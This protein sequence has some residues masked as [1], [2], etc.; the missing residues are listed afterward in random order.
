[1]LENVL[2]ATTAHNQTRVVPFEPVRAVLTRK[3]MDV[4]G[5]APDAT[6]YQAIAV[7]DQQRVGALVVL[8]GTEL[9]GIIS[10]RDYARKVILKGRSS[11]ETLVRDIMTQNVITVDLEES[12]ET[13]L[14]IM[15][16]SRIRH[17]PV[18]DAGELVG[19]VSIGDLVRSIISAQA[20]VLD[21]LNNYI[22]GNYPA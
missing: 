5:I 21:H 6:V 16:N 8:S 18:V 17:L 2:P 7:M 14:R 10:E 19:L 22:A 4:W 3:G 13:C 11:K 9:A 20:Q 1:M 12:V 15:T